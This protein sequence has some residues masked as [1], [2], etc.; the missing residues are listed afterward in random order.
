MDVD[1]LYEVSAFNDFGIWNKMIFIKREVRIS[2]KKINYS[3]IMRKNL[4]EEERL[5][6]FDIKQP[7]SINKFLERVQIQNFF[8]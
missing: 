3:E 6:L 2:I 5:S 8:R 4:L 1:S 7:N